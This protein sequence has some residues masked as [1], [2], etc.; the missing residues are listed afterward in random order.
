MRW[1]EGFPPPKSYKSKNVS[2]EFISLSN[3]PKIIQ[4]PC[5]VP[6]IFETF[7]FDFFEFFI[8]ETKFSMRWTEGIPPP[9]SHKSKNVSGEFISLSKTP[10]IIRIAWV[11]ISQLEKE[12]NVFCGF[13]NTFWYIIARTP[14]SLRSA[15][16]SDSFVPARDSLAKAGFGFFYF[17][18]FIFYNSQIIFGCVSWPSW[19]LLG[20]IKLT[21]PRS[22]RFGRFTRKRGVRRQVVSVWV[23]V[24]GSIFPC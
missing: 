17:I 13:Q 12:N 21:H 1:T 5:V 8:C 16:A 10:K 20:D 23:I 24:F 14:L 19:T 6:E 22:S 15:W 3:P 18:L 2:G 7:D 4:I 11:V 9:K